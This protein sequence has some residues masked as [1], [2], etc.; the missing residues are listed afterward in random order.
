MALLGRVR[1]R[2]VE[3]VGFDGA[4]IASGRTVSVRRVDSNAQNV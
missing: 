2:R 1:R 4:V 3:T